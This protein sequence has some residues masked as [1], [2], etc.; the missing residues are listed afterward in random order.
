M[1]LILR[2]QIESRQREN[3]LV[4]PSSCALSI[5]EQRLCNAWT[6]KFLIDTG[7]EHIPLPRQACRIKESDIHAVYAS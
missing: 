4:R 7:M 1:L 2:L 6:W 3:T 5:N